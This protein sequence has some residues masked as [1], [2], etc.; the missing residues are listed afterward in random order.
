MM[1][2]DECFAALAA[3]RENAIVVGTYTSAFEWERIAPSPLN[4]PSTGAMGQGSSHALGLA[5]GLPDQRVFVLDGDGGLLMNLGTL[6]TIAN[7][8]PPNLFH[9]L[10]ENGT[11]EAN[12]SHPLPNQGAID[13]A[14]L[15]RDAGYA[16]VYAFHDLARFREELPAVLAQRGPVFVN[17]KIVPGREAVT[18]DYRWM[19]ATATRDRFQTGVDALRNATS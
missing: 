11:Y 5:L 13:F 4:L 1:R 3:V 19:H 6:V 7:A 18:Y 16:Q 15:A 12:G 17:L 14:G 9:F 8:A 2:R 10:C